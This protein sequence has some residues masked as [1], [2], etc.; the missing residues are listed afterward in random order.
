MLGFSLAHL[1]PWP[2][3]PMF[4][5]V[6]QT[7][8]TLEESVGEPLT[9]D[10][11]LTSSCSVLMNLRSRFSVEGEEIEYTIYRVISLK[12][13]GRSRAPAPQ[14]SCV[15][16][17]KETLRALEMALHRPQQEAAFLVF[18]SKELRPHSYGSFMPC[19]ALTSSCN[20]HRLHRLWLCGLKEAEILYRWTTPSFTLFLPLSPSWSPPQ[21]PRVGLG[22][23]PSGDTRTP[24]PTGCWAWISELKPVGGGERSD[25]RGKGGRGENGQSVGTK[26]NTQE[27]RLKP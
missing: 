24:K 19:Q 20:I 25:D 14:M 7:P 16:I 6:I 13:L 11:N 4:C 26:E 8:Y 21:R 10:Y 12:T 23:V 18:L 2:K 22:P 3:V 27:R 1:S 17:Y 5:H 15:S 9:L